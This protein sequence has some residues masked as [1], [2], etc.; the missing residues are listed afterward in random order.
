MKQITIYEF[1]K[2]NSDIIKGNYVVYEPDAGWL[3]FIGKPEC[4][5][6][7]W[8]AGNMISDIFNIEP[9]D[10]DWKDSLIKVEHKEEE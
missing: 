2:R 5:D 6:N 4:C 1:L 9:F 7:G 10:G 8:F 3:V